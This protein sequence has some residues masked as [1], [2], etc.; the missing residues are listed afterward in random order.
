MR[1]VLAIARHHE[2]AVEYRPNRN[3]HSGRAQGIREQASIESAPHAAFE[4]AKHFLPNLA[5]AIECADFR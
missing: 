5:T 4:Q 2:C 1:Q 3:S